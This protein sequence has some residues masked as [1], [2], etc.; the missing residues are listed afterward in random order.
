MIIFQ[1]SYNRIIRKAIFL[2]IVRKLLAIVIK[3]IKPATGS[4]D[5]ELAGMVYMNLPNPTMAEAVSIL[6]VVEK[7]SELSGGGIKAIESVTRSDPKSAA[8]ILVN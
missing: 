5:P 7:T 4:S 6:R 8:V 1:Y 3:S 2:G